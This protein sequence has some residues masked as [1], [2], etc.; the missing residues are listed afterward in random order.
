M[1]FEIILHAVPNHARAVAQ[2][3]RQA[4]SGFSF[5]GGGL[6]AGQSHHG[7]EK[8]KAG[9]IFHTPPLDALLAANASEL[10]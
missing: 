10:L 5:V 3:H 6:G 4:G 9:G 2:L 8:N 7:A 1:E